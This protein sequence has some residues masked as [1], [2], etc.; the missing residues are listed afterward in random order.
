M[1]NKVVL[2]GRLTRDPEIRTTPTNVTVANFSL[3]VE[4]NFA[5]QGEQRQTD[6]I[7]IVTFSHTAEFVSKYFTKGQL[8]AVA[9]R[10]QS[11]SWDGPD[12]KKHFAT[13][14]VAE[15]CHFAEAKRDQNGS[16]SSAPRG[17]DQYS[18]A[19]ADNN[20]F[21]PLFDDDDNLP[22]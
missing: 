2:M 17:N 14:I 20:D 11:R 22:F 16:G 19:P 6:F 18:A 7:N 5:R 1:L 12:G 8:V 15:E 13:D 3:A 4:R 21:S 9:G 10:I